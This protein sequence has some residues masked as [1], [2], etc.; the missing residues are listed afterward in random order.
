[1]GFT[2]FV[3]IG[4]VVYINYGPQRGKTAV[5]ID[6]IDQNRA[7]ID[8]PSSI[9]GVRRQQIPLRR[10]TLT[11]IK[12]NIQ[13]GARLGTL[14][15][16]YNTANVQTTFAKTA[17]AKRVARQTQRRN[18][19]D[20]ERFQVQVLRRRRAYQERQEYSKLVS[21]DNKAR[22]AKKTAGKAK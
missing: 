6:V 14:V 4:R 17:L 7:F 22:I 12:L 8:G 21:A 16:A 5:I 15:K 13:R 2:K 19:N 11:N 1:M 9:T 3:E 20:F 10:L 18:L